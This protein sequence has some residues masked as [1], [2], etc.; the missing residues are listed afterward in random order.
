MA[1]LTLTAL[2]SAVCRGIMSKIQSSQYK[3]VC[4]HTAYIDARFWWRQ[5]P[6]GGLLDVSS[7]EYEAF[8]ALVLP[9]SALKHAAAL[10][11]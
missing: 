5:H 4:F 11:S 8:T 10:G 6:E 2:G 3:V 7:T 9:L 1:A